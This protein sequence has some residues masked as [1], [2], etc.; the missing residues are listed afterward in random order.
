MAISP[1]VWEPGQAGC[2]VALLHQIVA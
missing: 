2:A 1:L